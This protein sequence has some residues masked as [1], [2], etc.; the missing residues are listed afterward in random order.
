MA[1]SKDIHPEHDAPT[2]ENRDE[3]SEEQ[4]EAWAAAREQELTAEG[5]E[6]AAELHADQQ[7][8]LDSLDE[9]HGGDLI[10]TPVTLPGDN[11]AHIEVVLNGELMNRMG[12]VDET[13]ATIQDPE[14]GD[15]ANVERAMDEAS[16]VLADMLAEAKYSKRL[17]YTVYEKYGPDALGAHIEAV[18]E[19]VEQ[20][21]KRKAGDAKG[22]R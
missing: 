4:L 21:A 9:E 14:P 18:F 15:L 6:N 2:P 19:A 3:W 5:R 8:L 20:E 22:F 13:L 10:E 12:H 17:F 1:Q 7:E 16:A 11:L